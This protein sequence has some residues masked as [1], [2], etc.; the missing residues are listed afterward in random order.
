MRLSELVGKEIVNIVNGARLGVI[1]ESDLSLDMETGHIQS[2]ILPRRSNFFNLWVD[3][4]NIM[5]PWE[6][7]R[8][9]GEEVVIVEIDQGHL[10]FQRYSV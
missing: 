4:Q 10:N 9:I 7:V 1:G 8:K 5:I 6:N 3:K 2:I